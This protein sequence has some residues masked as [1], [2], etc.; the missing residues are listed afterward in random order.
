M[1]AGYGISPIG[2]Y[3]LD[4]SGAYSSFD[5]YMMSMGLGGM[6]GLTGMTGFNGLG[7]MSPYSMGSMGMMGMGM[8]NPTFMQQMMELQ[9][10]TEKSQLKHQS[11]MHSLLQQNQVENLS[12]HEKAIF[13]SA[14]VDGDIKEGVRVLATAVR[15]G[16]Q[17]AICQRYDDL[18]N[19]IY[20]KHGDYFRKN[21]GNMTS[22]SNVNNLIRLLYSQEIGGATGELVDLETDIKQYGDDPF[23]HG[24]HKAFLNKQDYH[25]RYAEETLRYCFGDPIDNEGGKKR[26]QKVGSFCGKVAEGAAGLVGGAGLGAVLGGLIGAIFKHPLQGAKIGMRLGSAAGCIGD[27]AWQMTR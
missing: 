18:K 1:T 5:P 7:T 4:M 27:I 14:M 25:K 23:W 15:S 9:Q 11:A 26:I 2:T 16:N 21:A 17:D 19:I 8:Y 13:E 6:D 10:N 3:G 20:T 22:L 24:F 12:Q